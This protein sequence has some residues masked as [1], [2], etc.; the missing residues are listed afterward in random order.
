MRATRQAGAFPALP[1]LSPCVRRL[2]AGSLGASQLDGGPVSVNQSYCGCA[3]LK[4]DF[5][6]V[7]VSC[8]CSIKGNPAAPPTIT[9]KTR[10]IGELEQLILYHQSVDSNLGIPT[11]GLSYARMESK[12]QE[13]GSVNVYNCVNT[14]LKVEHISP[15]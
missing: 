10:H 7:A 13:L 9:S 14:L 8:H 2:G 3:T 1:L 12:P 4:A 6:S 11:P 15:D 5:L